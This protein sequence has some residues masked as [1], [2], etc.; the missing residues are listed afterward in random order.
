MAE[1]GDGAKRKCIETD[2]KNDPY[3][4]N[5]LSPLAAALFVFLL[6]FANIGSFCMSSS[7]N[8]GRQGT[9]AVRVKVFFILLIWKVGYLR[10]LCVAR[11]SDE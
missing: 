8:L 1:D 3:N 7:A 2:R 6:H 11:Q 9:E 5:Q 10:G 4:A